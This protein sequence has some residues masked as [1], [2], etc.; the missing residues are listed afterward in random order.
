MKLIGWFGCLD[1]G[2]YHADGTAVVIAKDKEAAIAALEK[3]DEDARAND[4][5]AS[6]WYGAPAR[7]CKSEPVEIEI[8]RAKP[9]VVGVEAGCDC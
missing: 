1:T 4:G 3:Y 2:A 6:Y 5:Y 7:R 9:Q 8:G